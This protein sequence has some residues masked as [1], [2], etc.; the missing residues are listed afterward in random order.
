M[1][2][3]NYQFLVDRLEADSQQYPALFRFKVILVSGVAYAILCLFL[4]FLAAL[5][6]WGFETARQDHHYGRA[7]QVGLFALTLL[8]VFWVSPKTFFT[9]IEPPEGREL[10]PEEA[11]RFFRVLERI[12]K[13]LNGPPIHQVL[14]D[15]QY[16]AAICQVPRFGLFGGH[17]NYLIVGLPYLLA[18]P[19]DEMIATLAH[20]YGHLA[21]D[22]GKMGAWVYRQ[23][24]TF[25]A[26][27]AKVAQSAEGNW[28][29]GL[30]AGALDRFAP[31]FNAYTF[32]LSRQQEYEADAAAT[33]IAGLGPNGSGLIRD[34]LLGRWLAR[35]FW[36][37][38]YAQAKEMERPRFMPYA[39][40]RTALAA[41]YGEWATKERLTKALR[42][43]SDVEDTHP[44]LRERLEAI[45]A[46]PELPQL[47]KRSAAET[48]L[49]AG[50]KKLIDEFD[51]SW[52]AQTKK[53]WQS[54]YQRK[55]ATAR[56]MAE[57]LPRGRG[58][59][60]DFELQELAHLQA[61]QG[62]AAEALESLKNLLARREGP[63][64]RAELLKGRLLLEQGD[65]SGLACL[66]AARAA[67]ARLE[68]ECL[69]QGYDFLCETDG[70]EA[71]ERWV[72]QQLGQG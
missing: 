65:R 70:E 34:E 23:R 40:L 36:P 6:Y 24:Q 61:E 49:G 8:P 47:P 16:N 25:G 21:G 44:C 22:H 31:Y 7:L 26:I 3:R 14:L 50:L 11:E 15:D 35:A 28:V 52:W 32:V 19:E 46:P 4:V 39:S 62:E 66:V 53:G 59:L 71:A 2:D 33:R 29:N 10:K 38:L 18:T 12:R 43:N 13:K 72:N 1:S 27:H 69:Q 17:R 68:D 5:L 54:H 48:L 20:E 57:L 63:Y 64:P 45:E 58:N 41:C 60:S 56:R 51:A 55:M 30:M 67:D 42:R 37:R 9:R